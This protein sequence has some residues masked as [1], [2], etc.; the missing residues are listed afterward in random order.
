M[1]LWKEVL[2]TAKPSSNF[3]ASILSISRA[4]GCCTAVQHTRSGMHEMG[5][6][7]RRVI[8]R[9]LL[10]K[11]RCLA[12]M[13]RHDCCPVNMQ[14]LHKR[15]CRLPLLWTERR[16]ARC[17]CAFFPSGVDTTSKAHSVSAAAQP[18]RQAHSRR[19][20]CRHTTAARNPVKFQSMH[21]RMRGWAAQL[22]VSKPPAAAFPANSPGRVEP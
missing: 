21:M 17:C 10:G 4:S 15:S 22:A 12:T 8:L 9:L 7:H 11:Q 13:S 16:H 5:R 20:R 18:G 19:A 3:P 2:C 1:C 14:G 6:G